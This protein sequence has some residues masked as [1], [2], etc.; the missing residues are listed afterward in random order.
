MPPPSNLAKTATLFVDCVFK[1]VCRGRRPRRPVQPHVTTQSPGG[2]KTPPY[3]PTINNSQPIY[4]VTTPNPTGR[5]RLAAK[6]MAASQQSWPARAVQ[7]PTGALIAARPRNAAP[8]ETTKKSQQTIEVSHLPIVE[9]WPRA[10]ASPSALGFLRTR[11]RSVRA[12]REPK[13]P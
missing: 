2:V 12:K 11:L 13:R 1:I 3:G 6:T 7:C 10:G 9:C 8:Y 4:N 5:R